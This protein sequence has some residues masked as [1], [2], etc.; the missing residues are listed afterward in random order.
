[1]RDEIVEGSVNV[2]ENV[3]FAVG[4]EKNYESFYK[5]I[6]ALADYEALRF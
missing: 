6:A 5:D 2:I 1:L 3:R 4:E